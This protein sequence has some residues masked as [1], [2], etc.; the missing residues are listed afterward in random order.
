MS[1]GRRF[2]LAITAVLTLTAAV[3][4]G[5]I[6]RSQ[7]WGDRNSEPDGIGDLR[8]DLAA[9]VGKPASSFLLETIGGDTVSIPSSDSEQ[10]IVIYFA[11]DCV[12]CQADLAVWRRL[13]AELCAAELFFVTREDPQVAVAFWQT[14][15]WPTAELCAETH[16]GRPLDPGDFR[17]AYLAIMTPVVYL[18]DDLGIIRQVYVGSLGLEGAARLKEAL[19][20]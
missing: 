16:V 7:F 17:R 18:V 4:A 13:A 3:L 14:Y 2:E 11:S 9:L 5:V 20:G 8:S 15:G 10:S 6:L 19:R 12:Y 1:R